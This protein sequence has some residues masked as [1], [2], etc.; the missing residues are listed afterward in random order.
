VFFS[1]DPSKSNFITV[2]FKSKPISFN[3]RFYRVHD[4][5]A[6]LALLLAEKSC[7]VLAAVLLDV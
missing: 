3:Q 4:R 7:R 6:T 1:A 2:S 5:L